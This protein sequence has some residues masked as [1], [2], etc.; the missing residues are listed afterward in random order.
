MIYEEKIPIGVVYRVDVCF[1]A[2][3]VSWFL[4]RGAKVKCHGCWFY[5]LK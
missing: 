3:H 1:L 2:L 5:I 4:H